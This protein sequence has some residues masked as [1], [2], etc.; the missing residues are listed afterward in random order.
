MRDL[1]A[2]LGLGFGADEATLRRAL[3]ASAD[4]ELARRAE[5]VLLDPARRAGHDA[6]YRVARG[7]RDWRVELHLEDGDWA[8]AL[9][10]SDLVRPDLPSEPLRRPP[11]AA[12]P[13]WWRRWLGR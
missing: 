4:P 9:A 8:R 12:R 11:P 3:R 7:L 13:P 2:R 10:G 5:A 6:V 1:Y